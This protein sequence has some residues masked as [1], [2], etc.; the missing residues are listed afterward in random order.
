MHQRAHSFY[1]SCCVVAFGLVWTFGQWD[2]ILLRG[3]FVRYIYSHFGILIS[4]NRSRSKMRGYMIDNQFIGGAS[5]GSLP[6]VGVL[7][8]DHE[9]RDDR[10]THE[11]GAEWV[12]H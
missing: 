1:L 2:Q 5:V 11:R 9:S 6:P 7:C 12:F 4:V 8:G 10:F 3:S